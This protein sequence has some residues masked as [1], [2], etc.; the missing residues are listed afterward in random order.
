MQKKVRRAIICDSCIEN[1]HIASDVCECNIC[2][3]LNASVPT[4]CVCDKSYVQVADNPIK[5]ELNQDSNPPKTDST[6]YQ[7]SQ[8][9]IAQAARIESVSSNM[10]TATSLGASLSIASGGT[11]AWSM[12]NTIQIFSF[13]S[14]LQ[15]E[16]PLVLKSYLD[17][18]KNYYPAYDLFNE[19]I[20]NSQEP[21]KKASEFGYK[22]SNF[23]LNIGKPSFIII[24]AVFIHCLSKLFL[25]HSKGKL[26]ELSSKVNGMLTY[27][28]YLRLFI[29]MY[30]EFAVPSL[31]Q[32]IYV[33]SK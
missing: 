2:Y 6:E 22:S 16:I 13:L 11:N 14:L 26:K 19:V 12:L 10:S 20:E 17:S 25:V 9:E 28:V 8:E 3:S 29:Q 21:F 32:L 4:I 7:Y 24:I 33:I 1:A 15:V 31:L 27:G 5:C 30:I 23:I 18:Q